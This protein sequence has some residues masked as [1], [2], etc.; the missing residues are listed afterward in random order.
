ML[1][2]GGIDEKLTPEICEDYFQK[3]KEQFELG[4][5]YANQN[6]ETFYGGLA[7]KFVGEQILE[8]SQS[9][10]SGEK[11]VALKSGR[12][13]REFLN[14]KDSIDM[15]YTAPKSVSIMAELTKNE[16]LRKKLIE[17][18][19]NSAC[20]VMRYVEEN[21]AYTRKSHRENGKKIY[22]PVYPGKI[23]YAAFLHHDTREV[24]P[25]LHIHC[26]IP[27]RLYVRGQEYALEVGY[28]KTAG[29]KNILDNKIRLG[30]Y[31]R[32]LE[33]NQL[34]QSDIAVKITDYKHFFFELEGV[35]E[36]TL[37]TFS[38]R[39]EQIKSE[40]EKIKDGVAVGSEAEVKAKIALE[41]RKKKDSSVPLNELR[42]KWEAESPQKDIVPVIKSVKMANADD[43]AAAL[44]SA[45]AK[46]TGNKAPITDLDLRVAA[47]KHLIYNDL[48]FN[49]EDI[50]LKIKEMFKRRE[51]VK[52]DADGFF[53]T[54][55]E[56]RMAETKIQSFAK[57]TFE[58][59]ESIV[60]KDS[61]KNVIEEWEK[62]ETEKFKKEKGKD[63]SLTGD[64]NKVL[65]ALLTTKNGVTVIQ[66][67]AGTGKTTLLKAFYEITK[68][69][70]VELAGLSTTGK[71]VKEIVE[72]SMIDSKTI[73]SHILQGKNIKEFT[74]SNGKKVYIVD[75][76]S[77]NATLK[78]KEVI[79]LA[80]KENA[81]V[82]LIG[83]I[84]QLASIQAGGMFERLQKSKNV[85]FVEM[86]ESIRQTD[87]FLKEAV[88]IIAK[89]KI[90][91]GM[92]MLDEKG[93]IHVHENKEELY[94]K[95]T[96]AFVNEGNM[97]NFI[98]SAQNKDRYELNKITREK[99][100]LAKA[101][102]EEDFE[103]KIREGK[104]IGDEDKKNFWNYEKGDVVVRGKHNYKI[105]NV[106]L[107]NKSV[108]AIDLFSRKEILM[109][110]NKLKSNQVYIEAERKFSKGDKII[111][112]KNDYHIEVIKDGVDKKEHGVQNGLS[113]IIKNIE[114]LDSEN[115]K[116]SV[117]I[118]KGKTAIFET[119][120]Y[121]YF[122]HG[123][124]I[125]SYKSQGQTAEKVYIFSDRT[126][127]N[128][129]YVNVSRAKQNIEIFT[130]D[131]TLLFKTALKDD[132]Q[133]DSITFEN[134]N[135]RNYSIIENILNKIQK[136]D[137]SIP[138]MEELKEK[139]EKEN[140]R[141]E[142]QK[143][144]TEKKEKENQ[145]KKEKTF[146]G[147][148]PAESKKISRKLI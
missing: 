84:K 120:D 6:S 145:E 29:K 20:G 30:E 22:D 123:Y 129:F 1:T 135:Y 125:T 9:S 50:N 113:G 33:I 121:N 137:T 118:G 73:D 132:K 17:I 94:D 104:N 91:E 18:H 27:K 42:A 36:K 130:M 89:G 16:E 23:E 141:K 72:Q 56:I 138:S 12:T 38:K 54:T 31:Y 19:N 2:I 51:L 147:E 100:K 8:Q 14:G 39:S 88:K 114:R 110:G 78:I 69:R 106:D 24:D 108:S 13:F 48:K 62:N 15:T 41:T 136:I 142:F 115:C 71:A 127:K 139:F 70:G 124:A 101:I 43:I 128:E 59:Y 80:E 103:I 25:N 46:L 90:K 97:D 83:D 82:I 131:K 60:E 126:T 99:L 4:E 117:D 111:F 134:R 74:D 58:K 28:S 86:H 107:E 140:L 68:A 133:V 76:S 52:L 79:E 53:L 144:K 95:I 109:S 75:E 63:F 92:K 98:L 96:D 49:E 3:Q 35:E 10:V 26:I 66:G 81:R 143:P 40:Y 105:N 5:Y 102:D 45:T 67:D 87:P 146:S 11:H 77:M 37:E 112:L 57:N 32:A 119:K 122:T 44:K 61:I 64:Q 55:K 47:M 85:T 34:R 148:K 116:I 93:K 65:E 21:L 7:N